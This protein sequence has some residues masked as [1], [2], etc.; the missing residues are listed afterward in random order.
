MNKYSKKYNGIVSELI[1]NS[2]PELNNKKIIVVHKHKDNF[3][4]ATAGAIEFFFFGMII[5]YK[6]IEQYPNEILKGIFAHELAHLAIIKN[7]NFFELMHF[8]MWLFSKK[9]RKDFEKKAD[10]LAIHR[11]YGKNLLKFKIKREIESTKIQIIKRYSKG[12]LSPKEVKQ[13]I[14]KLK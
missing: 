12:Y 9:I 10:L 14:K 3:I 5:T 6:R 2:F 7:M 8:S 13:E 1:N 4:G 11:G